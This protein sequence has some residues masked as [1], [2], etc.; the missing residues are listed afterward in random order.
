MRREAAEL[1]A[2]LDG[3]DPRRV[4][5]RHD[6]RPRATGPGERRAPPSCR[7][8]RRGTC[9]CG[10]RPGARSARWAASV[11]TATASSGSSMT[12]VGIP[13]RCS[14]RTAEPLES[15]DDAHVVAR[16]VDPGEQRVEVLLGAAVRAGGEHLRRRGPAGGRAGAGGSAVRQA[17]IVESVGPIVSFRFVGRGGAGSARR[18]RPTRTC[19][20]RRRA[21]SRAGAGRARSPARRSAAIMTTP[22]DR[23]RASGSTPA[24]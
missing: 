21:G 15:D 8:S 19:R 10:R 11:P 13:A 23:S 9:G 6:V 18:P 16:P 12:V 7:R 2:V 24:L 4:H 22:G 1:V 17:G 14:L 20:A 3:A 5:R